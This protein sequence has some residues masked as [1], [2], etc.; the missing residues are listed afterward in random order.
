MY[1]WRTMN[2]KRLSSPLK[3]GIS[4]ALLGFVLT[5]IGALR[6]NIPL[7]PLNLAVALLIGGGVWFLVS[8]AVAAAVNEVERDDEKETAANAHQ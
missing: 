8:W 7:Q 2:W 4:F 5:A 3:I 1:N 6:G